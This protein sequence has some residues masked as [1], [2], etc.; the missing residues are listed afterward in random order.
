MIAILS[1]T[2]GPGHGAEVVLG[3]LLR[4]WHDATLPITVVA[5]PASAPASI[6]A[7]L[8]IPW[9]PL[10]TSRDALL[11]NMAAAHAVIAQVRGCRLVHAW[12][13]RGL[14]LSWWIGRR[15]GV[16]AT[17]TLHDH[18]E[19]P[20]QTWPRKRLWRVTANLQD[21]VAFPSAALESAWRAAGFRRRSRVIPNGSSGVPLRPRDRDAHQLV[22]GFLGMYAP[23]KG[24]TIAQAWARADWSEHVRWA[25]FGQTSPALAESA[26]GL[27]AEFGRRVRF[28]GAQPRERIFGTVDILVHCSTAFDPFPTVLLEAA[29]A[30]LP[31]VASSLGGAGEIVAHGE[32]G[33]LFDPVAPEVG[34]AHL[35]RLATNPG[36]C[37]RLGAAARSRFE[38][39]F[40]AERMAQGYAGFWNAV[41]SAGC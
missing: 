40:R 36:L 29:E 28:E 37:A 34:L 17:A 35:R 11:V 31:V 26:A 12:S 23:W 6:A 21:A 15:L 39:L 32:T 8:R 7:E 41:L 14:E 13:A 4:A 9:V 30:G 2:H 1:T 25:F 10:R 38:R 19:A 18:P 3:E 24:F 22:I 16:P 33:F 20:G 27:A 5:P